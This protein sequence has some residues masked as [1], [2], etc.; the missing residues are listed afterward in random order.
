M[1]SG[2]WW[3]RK[4]R[5]HRP[6]LFESHRSSRC[7]QLRS[8]PPNS[9]HRQ[10]TTLRC[11][12]V[13]SVAHLKNSSIRF[14]RSQPLQARVIRFNSSATPRLNPRLDSQMSGDIQCIYVILSRPCTRILDVESHTVFA[15][16]CSTPIL[17]A[18]HLTHEPVGKL[19][20]GCCYWSHRQL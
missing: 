16:S 7:R 11:R 9:P 5:R 10:S 20:L 12:V 13:G 3:N 17:S 2:G 4:M 14:G 15:R 6:G 8:L 18:S 1:A 19:T